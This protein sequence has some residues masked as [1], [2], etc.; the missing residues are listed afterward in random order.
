VVKHDVADFASRF[1]PDDLLHGYNLGHE[2]FLGL[3]E[4]HG[5]VG[6][7]VVRVRLQK[8]QFLG[9]SLVVNFAVN[10]RPD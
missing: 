3:E 6:G 1:R 5:H 8:V 7:V 4:L 9:H 10:K 2:W